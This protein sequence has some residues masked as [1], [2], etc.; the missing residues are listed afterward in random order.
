MKEWLIDVISDSSFLGSFLGA[1]FTG[2]IAIIIFKKGIKNENQKDEEKK[3]EQLKKELKKLQLINSVA[4]KFIC[5]FI[6]EFKVPYNGEVDFK[7][8]SAALGFQWI[9]D[10]IN[11]F[12][13]EMLNEGFTLD[14]LNLNQLI[15]HTYNELIVFNRLPGEQK[16]HNLLGLI[17]EMEKLKNDFNSFEAYVEENIKEIEKL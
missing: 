7:L 10:N 8:E 9:V 13:D 5:E 12:N 4:I 16:G 17:E 15:N 11:K 3:K 14:Y 2:L 6:E 1:L